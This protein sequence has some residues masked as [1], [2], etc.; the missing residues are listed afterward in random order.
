MTVGSTIAASGVITVCFG[1]ALATAAPAASPSASRWPAP[2]EA[3]G[4]EATPS[5]DETLAFLRTVAEKLPEMRLESFGVSGA[6]RALPLVI[7]SKERA[8]TPEAAARTGKPVVLIQNGIHAGEID[9]KDA[10]L[11]LLRDLALGLDRDLLEAATLLVVPIYNVD[12]HERVSPYNRPNQD[13]PHAG[14]GFRTTAAGYDLNRDYL[15]LVAP[16]SRALIALVN[17]W[18]PHLHV[19][20]HVTDGVDHDWVLTYAVAEAPQAPPSVDTWVKENLP[21]AVAATVKAGHRCGPYVD[22]KDGSDPAKGFTSFIGGARYST[23]YFPLRGRPSILLELHSYKT[24]RQ[25]VEATQDF[26]RSLLRVIGVAPRALLDAVAA[27]EARTVALGR[28]DAPPS[29]ITLAYRESA[30]QDRIAFPVYEWSAST[31]LVTGR[32]LL[33]YHR[34]AVNP[35]IVPWSHRAEAAITALRPRGYIVMSGWPQIERRLA[36]HGLRVLRLAKP[37]VLDVDTAR[38]SSPKYGERPYQ[39]FTQV[40][41]EITHRSERR[42]IPAG[43]LWVPADQPDFEVAVE[44]L[45][46]ES[47]ESLFE[48]GMLS[49]LLEQKEY[50]DSRNLEE[51]AQ[52]MLVDPAL[53]AEWAEA[54]KDPSFAANARARSQWWYRRTPYFKAQEVGLLPVYRV[55]APASFATE[56]WGGP[57]D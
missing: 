24:Y 48:W 44:L 29:E 19:D 20:V 16:E 47:P 45:E 38:A 56:A 3:S 15:K 41:A 50:M 36:D 37:A 39:G 28:A 22:L 31:S 26:L 6:G 21:R 11:G 54:L 18:R 46:P 33:R 57:R 17:R 32:P 27:A 13:G 34:G 49:T 55:L 10:C 14:M 30:A 35:I 9:G 25:R 1:A 4:F 52:K 8:F 23:G 51:L 5:Y 2:A 12:G 7:V 53:A 43:A 42:V 40:S